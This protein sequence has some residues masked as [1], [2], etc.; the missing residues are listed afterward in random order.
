MI[1]LPLG[2]LDGLPCLIVSEIWVRLWIRKHTEFDMLG[3]IISPDPWPGRTGPQAAVSYRN[4][5]HTRL[6]VYLAPW[7]RGSV[8]S[9]GSYVMRTDPPRYGYLIFPI[10]RPSQANTRPIY[11]HC[12]HPS[13][14]LRS[15]SGLWGERQRT[16]RETYVVIVY[17]WNGKSQRFWLVVKRNP[18]R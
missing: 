9:L 13:Y 8:T 16:C 12:R 6:V 18:S 17:I 11:L 1:A 10:F 4:M 15:T 7:R 3:S 5:L 2:N 14:S